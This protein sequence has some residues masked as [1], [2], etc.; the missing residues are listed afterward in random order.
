MR[1]LLDTHVILWMVSDDLRLP[2]AARRIIRDADQLV[3]SPV[4]F[5]EMAIKT[6]LK[7]TDFQLSP[8]WGSRIEGELRYNGA[9]KLNIEIR[10]CI[11][12]STLPWHHRDPFDRLL[13]AQAIE[14]DL[15][16]LSR[17]ENISQYDLKVLWE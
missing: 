8:N 9:I 16:L 14:E 1:L 13:V 4:S 7:K 2:E 12:V 17:D 6:S 10:H 15:T 3:Y 11:K 5:W